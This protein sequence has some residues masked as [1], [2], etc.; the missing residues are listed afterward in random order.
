LVKAINKEK[1]TAIVPFWPWYFFK[2]I[3]NQLS[4]GMIRK[5]F[6]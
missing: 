6:G 3:M 1:N 4:P 5:V 2:V